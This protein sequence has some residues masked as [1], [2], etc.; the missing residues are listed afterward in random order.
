[1]LWIASRERRILG[2]WSARGFFVVF[3]WGFR[4]EDQKSEQ[5]FASKLEKITF[6]SFRASLPRGRSSSAPRYRSE[7]VNS[8]REGEGRRA[9][10]EQGGTLTAFC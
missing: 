1:L 8:I 4:T 5:G 2:R 9:K 7:W 6:L 3:S 10:R